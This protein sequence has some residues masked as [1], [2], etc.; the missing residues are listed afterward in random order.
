PAAELARADAMMLEA[1]DL[2]RRASALR[3]QARQIRARYANWRDPA[4]TEALRKALD[5]NHGND[6]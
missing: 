3:R 5:G 4:L 1:D 6:T 2:E